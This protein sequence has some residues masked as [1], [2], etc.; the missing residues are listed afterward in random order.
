MVAGPLYT[1]RFVRAVLATLDREPADVLHAQNVHST[2]AA[3]IVGRRRRVP[4]VATVRDYR[5]LC[6]SAICLMEQEDLTRGCGFADYQRCLARYPSIYGSPEGFAATARFRLRRT[7]EWADW[8]GRRRHFAALAGAV[9]VGER[10]RAIHE[11]AGVVAGVH[12]TIPNLPPEPPVPHF[13][14]AAVLARLGLA[15]RRIVLHVGRVSVGKGARVLA[16]AARLMPDAP[17]DVAFVFAGRV[18]LKDALPREVAA[19]AFFLGHV[20]REDL[21]ALYQSASVFVAAS[22]WQEPFSRAILEAMNHGLPIVA[23]DAGGNPEAITNG[24]TGILVP[25][26]DARALADAIAR[27]LADADLARRIGGNARRA[28]HE[29]FRAEDS[30]AALEAFYDRVAG[31]R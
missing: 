30:L 5:M 22:V 26:S 31:V 25:R 2:P 1:R 3:A 28:V 9:F 16:E 11:R 15:G 27:V 19:R 13:D 29:R 10:I 6:P 17:P 21:A 12:A 18:E 24:E 8:R 4:A 20:A 23:S 7:W 14:P